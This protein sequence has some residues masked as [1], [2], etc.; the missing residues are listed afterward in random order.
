M[1]NS[2]LS[3]GLGLCFAA[4]ARAGANDDEDNRK[5]HQA[6]VGD[7]LGRFASVTSVT[8]ADV[9]LPQKEVGSYDDRPYSVHYPS[10]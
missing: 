4:N 6:M 10:G 3:Q 9:R 5:T 7:G 2:R 1:D 8:T